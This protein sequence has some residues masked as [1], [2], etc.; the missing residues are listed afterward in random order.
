MQVV[1]LLVPGVIP[2]LAHA[3]DPGSRDIR[4]IGI[5]EGIFGRQ[6]V[7]DQATTCL[8][9]ILTQGDDGNMIGFDGRD[10]G[11]MTRWNRRQGLGWHL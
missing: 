3:N 2:L 1:W 7:A 5:E 9:L 8:L 6:Q 10:N 11:L 4:V